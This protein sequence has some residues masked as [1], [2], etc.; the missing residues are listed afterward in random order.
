MPIYPLSVFSKISECLKG[1]TKVCYFVVTIIIRYI[2]LKCLKSTLRIF[3]L[4]IYKV[5]KSGEE[6]STINEVMPEHIIAALTAIRNVMPIKNEPQLWTTVRTGLLATVE[7]IE[8]AECRLHQ[9]G[10]LTHADLDVIETI[11]IAKVHLGVAM[12]MVLCPPVLDPLTMSTTEH[13][14]LAGIVSF[15]QQALS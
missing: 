4:A 6:T 10:D 2:D 7:N 9:C 12:A 3:V 8:K 5:G 1:L 11:A 14:F 15:T 13:H